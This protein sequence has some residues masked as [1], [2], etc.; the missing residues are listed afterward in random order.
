MS[1]LSLGFQALYMCSHSVNTLHPA[2]DWRTDMH[3]VQVIRHANQVR[4]VE[5]QE[6]HTLA[7]HYLRNRSTSDMGVLGYIGVF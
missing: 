6:N 5:L 3:S 1:Q 2:V 4:Y 7:R